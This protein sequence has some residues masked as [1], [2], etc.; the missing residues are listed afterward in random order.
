MLPEQRRKLEDEI[1][2][3]KE[4]RKLCDEGSWQ[5]KLVVAWIGVLEARLKEFTE[6]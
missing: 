2:A 6:T 1:T 4:Y 3:L 5:D